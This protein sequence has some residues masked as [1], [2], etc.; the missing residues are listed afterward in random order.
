MTDYEKIFMNNVKYVIKSKGISYSFIEKTLNISPGYLTR[1]FTR[2]RKIPLS[3]AVDLSTILGKSIDEL[4]D[5]SLE[6]DYILKEY[7][8]QLMTIKKQEE[9][10]L[11]KIKEIKS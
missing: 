6:K 11:N 9:E 2:N 1:I 5:P 7:E 4:L 3:L 10:I 8:E